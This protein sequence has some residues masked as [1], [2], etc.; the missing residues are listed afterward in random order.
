MRM[1][2]WGTIAKCHVLFEYTVR[3]L[4]RGEEFG[5]KFPCP[6]S[7]PQ[8]PRKHHVIEQFHDRREDRRQKRM[9]GT[10]GSGP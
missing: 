7:V 1:V 10:L 9:Q 2:P 3:G 8:V 5:N 4:A 6:T